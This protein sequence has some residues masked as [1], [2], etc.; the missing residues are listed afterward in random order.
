MLAPHSLTTV[1]HRG[2]PVGGHSVMLNFM[3]SL[4]TII[5]PDDQPRL[6]PRRWMW[7]R[8]GVII[9]GLGLA[10]LVFHNG[11]VGLFLAFLTALGAGLL[12]ASGDRAYGTLDQRKIATIRAWTLGVVFMTFAW[13]LGMGILF[14]QL[15]HVTVTPG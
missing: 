6:M 5:V 14:V 3:L 2:M 15:F 12:V 7:T 13:L 11:I 10:A 8:I 9:G 1:Q 4:L